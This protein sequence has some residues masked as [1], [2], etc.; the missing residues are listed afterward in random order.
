MEGLGCTDKD[1]QEKKQHRQGKNTITLGDQL[2]TINHSVGKSSIKSGPFL[3]LPYYLHFLLQH[4]PVAHAWRKRCV[5]RNFHLEPI[6]SNRRR[7]R[8]CA[9]ARTLRRCR[10]YRRHRSCFPQPS[11]TRTSRTRHRNSHCLDLRRCTC[12]TTLCK[13]LPY[14]FNVLIPVHSLFSGCVC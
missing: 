13:W 12:S 8:G 14:H 3:C 7:R 11:R 6:H 5:R 2:A 4:N 1:E 9:S 10:R